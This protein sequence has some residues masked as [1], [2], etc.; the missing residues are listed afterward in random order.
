MSDTLRLL[1]TFGRAAGL[2][3]AVELPLCLLFFHKTARQSL[4]AALA[5]LLMNLLT[6]P[7]LNL[8]LLLFYRASGESLAVYYTAL[9]LGEL[10]VVAA[11]AA[12][13][14]AMLDA[15]KKRAFAASLAL[16]AASFLFGFFIGF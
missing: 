12:I 8:L 11:E 15:S 9:A 4:M 1:G 6:N 14:R 7:L 10:A 16:N 3:V 5:A 2:T 13:L